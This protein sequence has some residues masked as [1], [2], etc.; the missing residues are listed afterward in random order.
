MKAETL[1]MTV[2]YSARQPHL[3]P[4]DACYVRG[5]AREIMLFVKSQVMVVILQNK[6][7]Y[8]VKHQN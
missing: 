8:N 4:Y 3:T 5:D 6:T 2:A 7:E 1:V